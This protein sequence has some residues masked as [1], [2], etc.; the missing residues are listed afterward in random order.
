MKLR[1]LYKNLIIFPIINSKN[2][3]IFIKDNKINQTFFFEFNI[4]INDSFLL[5]YN[6]V[7][8]FR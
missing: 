5:K 7:T 2:E 3:I 1:Q 6:M 4:I 8:L